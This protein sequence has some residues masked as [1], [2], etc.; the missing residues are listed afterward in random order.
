MEKATKRKTLAD[1]PEIAA[2]FHPTKNGD[3]TPG[4][5]VAGSTEKTWWVCDK[6][7]DH[8]WEASPRKRTADGQGI[9][10]S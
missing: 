10:R 6:G 4:Q 1:F 5:V 8:E 3:L 9:N 7:L 2:Q